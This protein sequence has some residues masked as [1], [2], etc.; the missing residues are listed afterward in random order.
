MMQCN[1]AKVQR[2]N[3]CIFKFAQV[4]VHSHPHYCLVDFVITIWA[5]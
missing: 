3:P 2:H 1:D 4:A 5:S